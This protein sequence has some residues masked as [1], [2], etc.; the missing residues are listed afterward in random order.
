MEEEGHNQTGKRKTGETRGETE[1]SREGPEMKGGERGWREKLSFF[2]FVARA[3]FRS[4]CLHPHPL[5]R[6]LF[7]SA[8]FIC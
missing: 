3:L 1:R 2:V 7:H 8:F 5:T 6:S 4:S